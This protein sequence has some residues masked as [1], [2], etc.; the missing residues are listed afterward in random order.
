MTTSGLPREKT[1]RTPSNTDHIRS[2]E[3][4]VQFVKGVGPRMAALLNKLGVFSVRDLLYYFPKRHEDR[5]RF[6]RISQLQ[7]GE[8]STVRGRV[9]ASENKQVRSSMTIT[10]VL[11]DD[12][13][14]VLVLSWFNQKFRKDQF[15]KLKGR[16]IVAYGTAKLDRWGVTIDTPEWEVVTDTEDPLSTGRVVPV[17]ALTEGLFQ[18][19][20]RAML[21]VVVDGFVGMVNDPMP[22]EIIKRLGMM[23]LKS[24]LRAI[25]FPET[26]V[27]LE[28][29]RKRLVF[30]E[31][32]LLQLAL[33]VRKRGMAMPGEGIVFNTPP[34]F[35]EQV[36]EILP[37]ELTAA[38]KRV[39]REIIED[40]TQP[41][42]MNR[43]LQGDVG[44]GKTAV[45][46][47]AM[48]LAV[49][50][51]YQA[52]LMAPTEILA[53]QHYIGISEMYGKLGA[54]GISV[55][56]LT[57]SLR[58]KQRQNVLDRVASG[59]TQIVIG[60]H[61]LI[62]EGVDFKRLGLV[63][64]D[65]Q[66]RFGVMQR[67]AL[68]EKGL[69]PDMLVMT[70]TPIP[71]TLTL[72]VYGDLDVSIID[73]LPP[74]RKPIR[75]HWKQIG[76]RASVYSAL[77]KLLDQGRQAYVVCPLIEE[78]EKLQVRA[79]SDLA[80][81][82][83]TEV[84]PDLKVG[85]LHGQMKTDE[86]DIV[87]SQFR[88]GSIQVLVSTTVIEVGVDVPNATCMV[89]EDADRFGLAQLHQLRGRVGR[90]SEQSYCV[91]ICEANTLDATTRMQV[92]SSTNDGFVI[93]EEDL[94][95]RGPGEFYGTKQ[96]GIPELQ[97]ADIFRDLPI[98]DIARKEAFALVERDPS[99][100]GP[101]V[102]P[103]KRALREK[104]DSFEIAVVS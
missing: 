49:R 2:L 9:L 45:A 26:E 34:D 63:I 35:Y 31:L 11:V 19:H 58:A 90:G 94:K 76:E 71:R 39:V 46:V 87:M 27:I 36:K 16:E 12:G 30:D 79:A 62:Q 67:A 59:E 73:E 97:I 56:L 41:K 83:Q 14:G 17:Y 8:A 95:L 84:F 20:I 25:H 3:M 22:V 93:S 18:A 72:T 96:S 55:D 80:E 4:S 104:F 98:L 77:R 10:K 66:H 37:F 101:D 29:A 47:A 13:S 54:L 86:K 24:A 91:L 52:A 51:G 40:M 28:A 68:M 44:S 1:V 64:V 7:H 70:A 42:C 43:L 99:L 53:E 92:M 60:T 74:G 38:Q 78:S 23:D 50:S 69:K 75:T 33:A 102:A 61:A 89:I 103:V 100:A 85:L 82:L 5:T 6:T 48:L 57:G 32:F 15:A 21:R 65:E 88:D 81:Y